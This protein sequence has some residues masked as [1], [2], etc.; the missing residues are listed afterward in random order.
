MMCADTNRRERGLP[1]MVATRKQARDGGIS[2]PWGLVGMLVLV[3]LVERYVSKNA[4][5]FLDNED[6]SFRNAARLAAQEAKDA[7]VLVV[8]DSQFKAGVLPQGVAE[9]CGR[10]TLNLAMNGAQ[11]ET[12]EALLHTRSRRVRGR[13]PWFWTPFPRCCKPPRVSIARIGPGC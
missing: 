8:G 3:L 4:L 11:I 6:W 2:G 7:K 10:K 13:T 12:G 9:R 5:R 1:G